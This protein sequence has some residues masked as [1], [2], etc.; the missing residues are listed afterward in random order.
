MVGEKTRVMEP[1]NEQLWQTLQQRLADIQTRKSLIPKIQEGR[2][3]AIIRT[4]QWNRVRNKPFSDRHKKIEQVFNQ[5]RRDWKELLDQY[6]N[7]VKKEQAHLKKALNNVEQEISQKSVLDL[8]LEDHKRALLA[9][10]T[11]LEHEQK[12]VL[13]PLEPGETNW[14]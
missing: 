8:D 4:L 1:T 11:G 6:K 2:K 10:I 7:L 3:E 12:A 13:K 9:S 14:H 5:A